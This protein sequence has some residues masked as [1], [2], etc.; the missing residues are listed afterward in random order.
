MDAIAG[1]S[2]GAL[3]GALYASGRPAGELERIVRSVDWKSIFNA[4]PDRRLLPV[5]SRGD[6]R[7]AIAGLGIEPWRVRL[8][9]GAVGDYR[10][11]RFLIEHLAAPGYE[12]GGDFDR[13]PIRFRAV[14]T[15]LDTGERVVLARG[16]LPRAVRASASIPVV[17]A[18]VD[19]EGRLLVDGGLVD[20]LPAGVA[21]EMGADVVVAVDVQSPP[22][23]TGQYEDI[24]GVASQVTNVLSNQINAG[25]RRPA[26]L[27]IRPDLGRHSFSDY[28][29]LDGLIARGYEAARRALPAIRDGLARAVA[30]P[31][32]PSAPA[33]EPARPRLEGTPIAE[34][35]VV[36]NRATSESL[37]RRT[38]NIPVGPPFVLERA[39]LAL[40]KV[41]ALELFDSSMMEF[42]PAGGGR[43]LRIL[44][45]V[46]E[47]PRGRVEV[48]AGYNEADHAWGML[49][50]LNRNT[51]G[52]EERLEL[53]L[54][55]SDSGSSA[56]LSLGG[57]R[58][59]K[60]ILGYEIAFYTLSDRPRFFQGGIEQGRA[61]FDRE[62]LALFLRRGVKR[63]GLLEAGL[64]LGQVTT[65][66][67]AGVDFPAGEDDARTVS[68]RIV[69]DTLDD[70]FSPEAGARFVLVGQK[71]PRGLGASHDF[72]R[73]EL[74]GTLAWGAGSRTV[75][76]FDGLAG[77]SEGDLPVYERF[78]I[79][80][81]RL[82][83]GF[84]EGELW[85]AQGAAAALACR[86]RI[87]GQLRAVARAGTGN[88]WETRRDVRLGGLESGFSLGLLHLTRIGPVAADLG[89][90]RDG[91]T[92]F[93]V[94][95][96]YR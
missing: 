74:T 81:P 12:A 68:G 55:A 95:I 9:A 77:L 21:R 85:G 34:V 73:A 51:L 46:K 30:T 33:T 63:W 32:V 91:S 29:G 96:G 66:P 61:R 5:A 43:E 93:T 86:V 20:N 50:L 24:I 62:G 16:D 41:H 58:I 79:G 49:R 45:R 44:L 1:T 80:G 60:P 78:R 84:R 88:V 8:P 64:T 75:L 7:A 89:V 87:F 23:E 69:Y 76:E 31:H 28:S 39:L 17:F 35:R 6:E 10:I 13:L 57:D 65:K 56:R 72:W 38:F 47:A 40:D 82:L 83:P 71:S 42:E 22:L 2:A 3:M 18:P 54:Q 53:R 90:R 14:A 11:D 37:V 36:G 52:F 4:R 27:L 67:R 70:L 94:S 48:G 92:L 25:H 19:W 59:V 15:A 26:D